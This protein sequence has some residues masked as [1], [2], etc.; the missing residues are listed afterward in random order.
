VAAA[1]ISARI[2]LGR[3]AGA[4]GTRGDVVIHAYT[5]APEDI[6]GYGPLSDAA[7]TRSFEIENARTTSKG[8]V[9]RLK[10]VA[11]RT[12]AE[13]LKGVELFVPRDRLPPAGEGE[14][15]HADLIGLSAVDSHGNAIGEIVA[16]ANYGA[17]DLLEIRLAASGKTELIPFTEAFVPE[18]DIAAKRVV[19]VMPTHTGDDGESDAM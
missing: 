16:V 2:L 14:F 7:G 8:V 4:H 10:G 17:G 18:I 9:A 3:I 19:V 11:N 15:Y 12:A 5:V 13:A 6:D 1:C